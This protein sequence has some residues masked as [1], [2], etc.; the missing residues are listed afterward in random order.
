MFV[1]KQSQSYFWPVEVLFPISG[2]KHDK[3]TFDV[4]FKRISQT[5]IKEIGK[6]ID[7]GEITDA[8]L[9]KELVVG[10][11]GVTDEKSEEMPFSTGAL[12]GLLDVHLVAAAIVTA[13]FGSLSAAKRKN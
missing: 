6:L 10:W 5:R 9:C 13:W 1:I 7:A 3:Q 12:E 2:G 8:D 4:E 11:K